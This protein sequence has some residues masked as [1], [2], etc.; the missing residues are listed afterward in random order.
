MSYSRVY[1]D[2]D[3]VTGSHLFAYKQGQETMDAIFGK[4]RA[5]ELLS[6]RNGLILGAAIEKHFDAGVLVIVPDL[7]EKPTTGMLSR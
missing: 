4:I 1:L 5:G 2:A 6:F 3:W 7:P